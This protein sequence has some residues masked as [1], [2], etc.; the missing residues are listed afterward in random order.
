M[1]GQETMNLWR[2]TLLRACLACCALPMVGCGDNDKPRFQNID[3]SGANYGRDFELL[4]PDGN[5]RRLSDFRGKVVMLFFGFVQCPDVCPT[6][7]QRAAAVR[8]LL[9]ADGERVQI[10]F[11][12]VDPERDLP[13]IL[14]EYSAAFDADVLGLYG[15]PEKTHETAEAFRIYFSKVPTTYGYTVDHT[16]TSYIYDPEGQLRLAVPYQSTAKS[17]AA[18][19]ALLLNPSSTT[20]K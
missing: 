3:I 5:T 19:V 7:L 18:D 12:T 15:T 10:I 17:I 16:A 2:R 4:D 1:K 8:R 11:I 9:E 6:A 14:R 13:V 20:N